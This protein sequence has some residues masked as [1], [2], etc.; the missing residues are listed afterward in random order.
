MLKGSG[1]LEVAVFYQMNI[2]QQILCQYLE[3]EIKNNLITLTVIH[4]VN[5]L[6][7]RISK[8]KVDVLFTEFSY[9]YSHKEWNSRINK[10][11]GKLCGEHHVKRVLFVSGANIWL[12]RRLIDMGFDAIIGGNDDIAELQKAIIH[13]M[14]NKELPPFISNNIR[15]ILRETCRGGTHKLSSKEWEVLYLLVQGYSL[16]EIAARKSR[17]VSTVATQKHNA[18]KKLDISSNSELIKFMQ[19][20]EM[21]E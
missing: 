4:T 21:M 6:V 3:D 17:A 5:E 15:A 13:V 18:M 8:G 10:Q 19:I 1:R 2:Y 16:S 20:A 12:L 7:E 9:L 11:F 14:S